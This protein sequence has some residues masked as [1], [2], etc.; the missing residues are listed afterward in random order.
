MKRIVCNLETIAKTFLSVVGSI[1]GLIAI[2]TAFISW[3]D[4]QI[5][6]KQRIVIFVI[7]IIISLAIAMLYVLL[8]RRKNC[9]WNN[10]TG[11][12]SVV[13]GD[14]IKIAFNGKKTKNKVVVIPVNTS[15]DTIV[16]SNITS[17]HKPLVSP[18]SIHGQWINALINEGLTEDE[19]HQIVQ[20]AIQKRELKIQKKCSSREKVRGNLDCYERGSLVFVSYRLNTTFMLV[21][22][23]DFDD[24]NKGQ[25][26]E[27]A[28]IDVIMSIIDAYN[29]C[30]QGYDLYI[31]LI[32]T[33][34]SRVNLSNKESLQ[35]I[36]A[37]I[38]ICKKKIHGAVNIVIYE[39]DIDKVTIFD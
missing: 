10:G 33:G 11:S 6:V 17:V 29:D 38:E 30:A 13:Y 2:I 24:C 18:N 5:S 21:A 12:L 9:I 36:K 34:F 15:F 22:L 27:E 20:E 28:F 23:A 39:E 25:C 7:A 32:G 4:L 14:I 37:C 8:I 31:P 16:D 26:T 19:I 3:D 35:K 1:L